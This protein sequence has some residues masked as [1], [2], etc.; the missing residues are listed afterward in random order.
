[1]Q[2]KLLSIAAALIAACAGMTT[3]RAATI[4]AI[5]DAPGQHLLRFDSATPTILRNSVAVT[6]LQP[7]EQLVGMDFRIS[8]SGIAQNALYGV[9]SFGRIYTIN[10]ATGAATFV[11]ALTDGTTGSP[12]LLNGTEFGVDFN[13][14]ADRLRV[15]SD[16]DQNLRINV[17]T[18]ATVSD[19]PLAPG[20]SNVTDVAYDGADTSAGTPT[21]LY[22][23]D[24]FSNQLVRIGG[25]DGTPSPNLGVVTPVGSLVGIDPTSIGGFD[26]ESGTGTAFLAAANSA[27]GGS[28]LSTVNLNTGVATL[29]GFIGNP[30]DSLIIK[31]MA[32]P[33]PEPTA[34]GALAV[35]A[36]TALARRRRN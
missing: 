16:L 17:D 7:N 15:V 2:T 3:A 13:P 29:V 19:V 18:G 14:Q 25:P 26:I 27:G 11:S 20:T 21:T 5:D 23:I 34:L 31:G 28:L 33:V 6:G 22:G 24:T 10:P 1:M 32:I 35:A 36:L 4:Y 9:G 12:V 30:E 8:A